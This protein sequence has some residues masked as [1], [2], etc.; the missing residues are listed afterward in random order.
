MPYSNDRVRAE[1]HM[2]AQRTT[3]IP[4]QPKK[5]TDGIVLVDWYTTDDPAN[6]QNWSHSKK[7]LVLVVLCYYTATV[8]AAGPSYAAAEEGI[9]Q[10]C[11]VSAVASTLGLGLYILAYGIGDLLFAPLSEIPVTGRNPVYYLTF[12][13]YWALSFP[14]ATVKNFC[15]LLALRFWLG[16]FGSPALANGGATIWDTFALIYIPVG[17]SMWVL[18]AWIGPVFGPLIGG[19]AAEAKGWKC[20]L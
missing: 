11:G 19:F 7:S 12:I 2:T 1:R 9:Q 16:F 4:I 13:V 14:T 15:G 17:L 5:T 8:Y 20:P 6:P 10:D 3:S 18:S